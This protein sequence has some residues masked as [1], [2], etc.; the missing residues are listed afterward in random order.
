MPGHNHIYIYISKAN[1][2]F[3]NEIFKC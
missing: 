2:C 1:F 3:Q